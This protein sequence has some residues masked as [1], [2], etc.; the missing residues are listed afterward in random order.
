MKQEKSETLIRS[1]NKLT[2]L[3]ARNA[4]RLKEA[5]HYGIR[6]TLVEYRPV[7][8][9]KLEFDGVTFNLDRLNYNRYYS[10]YWLSVPLDDFT[11]TKIK[12]LKTYSGTLEILDKWMSKYHQKNSAIDRKSFIDNVVLRRL[13]NFI[14]ERSIQ[15]NFDEEEIPEIVNKFIKD[16][17]LHSLLQIKAKVFLSNIFIETAVVELGSGIRLKQIGFDE[18]SSHTTNLF[19]SEQDQITSRGINVN[20]FLEI[21]LDIENDLGFQFDIA[22]KRI[23]RIV[24]NIITTLRLYKTIDICEHSIMYDSDSI[25]YHTFNGSFPPP[26]SEYSDSSFLPKDKSSLI[27]KISDEDVKNIGKLWTVLKPVINKISKKSYFEGE[28]HEIAFHRYIDSILRSQLNINRIS[29]CLYSL[30]ASLGQNSGQQQKN[31]SYRISRIIS[32]LTNQKFDSIRQKLQDAYEIRSLLVHGGRIDERLKTF[33]QENV[34]EILNITRI[35]LIISLQL[36]MRMTK[37]EFIELIK[38]ADK[39]KGI[40]ELSKV[41]HEVYIPNI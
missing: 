40:A 6:R 26:Y 33:A 36:Q 29:Y 25:L 9:I 34:R 4:I 16:I 41:L 3:T 5:N 7:K 18:L 2:V 8:D 21:N 1:L 14:S 20:C 12:K 22:Q 37:I 24:H 19:E 13:I 28:P 15:E 17:T 23:R 27:D 32:I 11:N 38:A 31:L 10:Y 30:D 35:I 39:K